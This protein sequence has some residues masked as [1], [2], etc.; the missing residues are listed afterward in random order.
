MCVKS[1]GCEC[2][3]NVLGRNK[4]EKMGHSSHNA[5]RKHI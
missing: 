1:H 4:C 5:N 3:M 2:R